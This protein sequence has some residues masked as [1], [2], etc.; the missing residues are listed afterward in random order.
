MRFALVLV[1][2][3]VGCESGHDD[4]DLQ[5]ERVGY[6]DCVGTIP[7]PELPIE[8]ELIYSDALHVERSGEGVSL[9]TQTGRLVITGTVTETG[10]EFEEYSYVAEIESWPPLRYAEIYFNRMAHFVDGG[11]VLTIEDSFNSYGDD[12]TCWHQF[13]MD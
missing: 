3:L 1:L 5:F 12:L 10:I 2:L 8:R 7:L 13:T 6:P 11:D 4:G 9:R